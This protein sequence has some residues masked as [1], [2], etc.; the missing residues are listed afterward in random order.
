[1]TKV[2]IQSPVITM[3]RCTTVH[4]GLLE[5]LSLDLRDFNN[6][7]LVDV[8]LLL[9]ELLLTGTPTFKTILTGF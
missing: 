3:K 4:L 2:I 9:Q 5:M 6:L 1:M 7:P 8:E